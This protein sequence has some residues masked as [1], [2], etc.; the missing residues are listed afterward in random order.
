MRRQFN[1]RTSKGDPKLRPKN[2]GKLTY[3]LDKGVVFL[4]GH[5]PL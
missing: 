2:D 5:F 3:G 4:F 1:Y